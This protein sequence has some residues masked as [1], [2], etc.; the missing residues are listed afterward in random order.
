MRV[1]WELISAA[2]YRAMYR[3]KVGMAVLGADRFVLRH[4]DEE[5]EYQALE[6]ALEAAFAGA[7]KG[8][9]IQ[10]YKGLGEMNAEQLWVTTM[11]PKKR[12]LLRVA[13]EDNVAADE[14]F[15]VLMGDQVQPRREFIMS[16]ALNVVNLDV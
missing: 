12:R 6:E 5:T 15:T 10:R 11:N 9:T 16:N 14:I 2:D 8:L 13:V 1:D 3:N 7:T 4:R